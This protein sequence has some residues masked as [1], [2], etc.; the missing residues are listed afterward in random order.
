MMMP[1]RRKVRQLL[2]QDPHVTVHRIDE[3]EAGLKAAA[4]V[5]RAVGQVDAANRAEQ[6]AEPRADV[7]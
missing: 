6:L 7:R 2:I 5:L 3:L 4:L 1:M